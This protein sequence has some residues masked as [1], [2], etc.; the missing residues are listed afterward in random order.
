[1]KK[2][3]VRN[4]PRHEVK[5]MRRWKFRLYLAVAGFLICV[6]AKDEGWIGGA[7]L[8]GLAVAL[9][10]LSPGSDEDIRKI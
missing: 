4:R 2:V 8:I 7:V 3:W 10:L 9:A 5:P 6:F 1:M